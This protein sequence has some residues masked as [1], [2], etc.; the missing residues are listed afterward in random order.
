MC[1]EHRSDFE[2]APERGDTAIPALHG[3]VLLAVDHVADRLS[4]EARACVK[5]PRALSRVRAS[6]A[7]NLRSG[8]PLK[9][10]PP[11]GRERAVGP[12]HLRSCEPT[13]ALAGRYVECLQRAPA[14]ARRDLVSP[15]ILRSF[16]RLRREMP[17]AAF[18][19]AQIH[20]RM[21]RRNKRV[22][23]AGIETKAPPVIAAEERGTREDHLPI[24]GLSAASTMPMRVR[25]RNL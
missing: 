2:A 19:C 6:N 8:V 3:D 11:L 1:S 12:G 4:D 10:R 24:A 23:H 25:G 15:R 20:A 22:V 7:M 5:R 9:T 21:H 18:L 16:G 14:A 17:T 13:D